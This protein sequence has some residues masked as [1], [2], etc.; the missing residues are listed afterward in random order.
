MATL[1][2][3]EI[4]RFISGA[5]K[6]WDINNAGNRVLGRFFRMTHPQFYIWKDESRI[7][8]ILHVPVEQTTNDIC[9]VCIN[10]IPKTWET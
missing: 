4:E 1:T 3:E 9:H 5:I 6:L 8:Q 2:R 7:E 10:R